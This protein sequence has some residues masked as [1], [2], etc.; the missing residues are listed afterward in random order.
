MNIT[1]TTLTENTVSMGK[2]LIGEHGISFLIETDNNKILFDTGQ[3]LA[4]LNNARVLGIDL[5][6]IDTVVLS[7]GHYDHAGGLKNLLEY[8]TDFTLFAHPES[9]LNKL[10][11]LNKKYVSIGSPV[12]MNFFTKKGVT[13]RL[14]KK[15]VEIAPNIITTGEIPMQTDFEDI[16]PRFF[17]EYKGATIPDDLADDQAVLINSEKG[18]I[19]LL[20][21]CHRGLINTLNHATNLIK[22]KKIFAV[23]GGLHLCNASDSKIKKIIHFL[24]D[25]DVKKICIGHC[26][27]TQAMLALF[28]EFKDRVSIN[29]PGNVI[30]L[31]SSDLSSIT[32]FSK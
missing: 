26:T 31:A 28:N 30:R 17:K 11:S 24:H 22:D 23:I 21:C 7:H 2:G 16:E 9:F 25:F 3:G 12:D 15:P 14:G 19:V 4:L 20:G 27:G 29:T 6:K 10:A 18:I 1:I 5:K 8:N 13:L 32:K